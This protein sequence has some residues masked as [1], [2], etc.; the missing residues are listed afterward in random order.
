M[1]ALEL[2]AGL[3]EGATPAFAY[4]VS[5]RYGLHDMRKHQEVPASSRRHVPPR[6]TLERLAMRLGTRIDEQVPAVEPIVRGSESIPPDTRA[7]SLGL[8][9]TSAPMAEPREK[10]ARKKP[11]RTRKKPRVRAIPQP[12][13]PVRIRRGPSRHD[14]CA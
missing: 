13:W 5:E 10:G 4:S 8:D 1:I 9:R 2:C 11:R 3:M 12:A 14:Q 6:A 7:L